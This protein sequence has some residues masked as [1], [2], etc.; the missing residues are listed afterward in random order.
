MIQKTKVCIKCGREKPIAR[1][2]EPGRMIVGRQMCGNCSVRRQYD[3]LRLDFLEAFGCKCSCCEE[4]HPYF[5]TLEH[6][7]PRR[8]KKNGIEIP[9]IKVLRQAKAEGWDR[10][11]YDCLCIA[12][13]FAKGLYGECPHRSGVTREQILSALRKS[14]SFR[15]KK[16]MPKGWKKTVDR[17]VEA[18]RMA[19]YVQ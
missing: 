9:R 16:A 14:A 6:V 15:V 18:Y 13:N 2:G 19:G 17:E 11:K 8:Y 12:C 5:L 7:V 10:T 3:R 1:Y 4:S